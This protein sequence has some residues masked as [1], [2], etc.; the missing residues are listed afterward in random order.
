VSP[1]AKLPPSAAHRWM[2]CPG[3]VALR[4]IPRTDSVYSR[5]GTFA[6]EIAADLLN[7]GSRATSA[8]GQTDGEFV[9]DAGMA[10]HL[11]SYLDAVRSTSLLTGG[12]MLVE[13]RVGLTPQVWGTA[14]ALVW[15]EDGTTLHVFDLKFG[16]GVPVYPEDNAQLMIYAVATLATFPQAC[17]RV[18][19][20]HL[21]IVQ[22][23]CPKDGEVHREWVTSTAELEKFAADLTSAAK[24]T[25][26][27][28]APLRAGDHCRFCP[29]APTCPALRESAVQAAVDV[30]P[31]GDISAPAAPPSPDTFSSQD[32]AKIL[33][34]ADTVE[35]WLKAI[36][37]EAQA[38]AE[39][40]L[41]VPGYK[42][43]ESVG[44]RKWI[45]ENVAAAAIRGSGGN[46]YTQK[47]ISPAQ[48]EKL[49]GRAGK[50]LVAP[51]VV[52]PVSG[53]KLVPETD[54]RP[55]ITDRASVFG[56]I[57]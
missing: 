31:T 32:L 47:I 30:F 43:V 25:E 39:R 5:E 36:R 4:D 16:A 14:D 22:P 34:T 27:P 37:A 7:N 3:S 24:A 29:G 55:A 21:H 35:V 12:T 52:R 28:D 6:H 23:R 20:V 44:N 17:D 51:L 57:E 19:A 15:S 26:Q 56:R 13:H 41:A 11:Q 46:P 38:R 50:P 8:V 42:L 40:G 45:D 33:Q 18:R 49:L 53:V 10:A 48:A 2:K 54:K 9:V 1:H